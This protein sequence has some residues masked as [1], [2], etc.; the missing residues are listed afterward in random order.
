MLGSVGSE[1]TSQSQ[2]ESARLEF[3][4]L[5]DPNKHTSVVQ[6]NQRNDR[7]K[8]LIMA[9]TKASLSQSVQQ[10]YS[11]P[12]FD[13]SLLLTIV[14][15]KTIIVIYFSQQKKRIQ[16]M[17]FDAN[18][19]LLFTIFLQWSGAKLKRGYLIFMYICVK[20]FTLT[21][22]QYSL[23]SYTSLY[24]I[25]W[26][27]RKPLLCNKKMTM[28][29]YKQDHYKNLYF[30]ITRISISK[31]T[32]LNKC[33]NLSQNRDNQKQYLMDMVRY[34]I[35]QFILFKCIQLEIPQMEFGYLI[36]SC[37]QQGNIYSLVRS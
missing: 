18:Q 12:T 24:P 31:T 6:A 28:D 4:P 16:I 37:N 32:I 14:D 25:V 30:S 23:L 13:N 10:D 27:N 15:N 9:N 26:D 35:F 1:L 36:F 17:D 3:Q 34:N 29:G 11:H 33:K 2:R 8:P 21:M 5:L 7:T 19:W 20:Y 22:K